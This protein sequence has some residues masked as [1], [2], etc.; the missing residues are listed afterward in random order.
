MVRL[1]TGK[2]PP[3]K[4][5]QLAIDKATYTYYDFPMLFNYGFVLVA[6]INDGDLVEISDMETFIELHKNNI[7]PFYI[8]LHYSKLG[9]HKELCIP[10]EFVNTEPDRIDFT[11]R[12][13]DNCTVPELLYF[14]GSI[15][16]ATKLELEK[17]IS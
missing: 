13:N 8:K 1:H 3:I 10:L 14:R 12:P 5:H 9:R 16:K 15:S 7:D 17:F 6:N 11:L 4:E 2:K